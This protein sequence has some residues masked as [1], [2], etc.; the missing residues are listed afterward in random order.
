M[1][2]GLEHV[3]VSVKTERDRRDDVRISEYI[4]LNRMHRKHL[5]VFQ[6]IARSSAK[7]RVR[8]PRVEAVALAPDELVSELELVT[9]YML[10]MD[11]H[12]NPLKNADTFGG[13]TILEWLRGYCLLEECY[14]GGLSES[15]DGIIRIDTEE[16]GATR[17]KELL[18]QSSLTSAQHL[19]SSI[20]TATGEFSPQ[21]P[22]RDDRT[23]LAFI[24]SA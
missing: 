8:N 23:A 19:C 16:F 7:N 14:A 11:L 22:P 17:V 20:L 10:D 12:F 3:I 6:N 4:A 13:L 24:H 2:P 18:L 15:S 9:L 21:T 1:L 5:V